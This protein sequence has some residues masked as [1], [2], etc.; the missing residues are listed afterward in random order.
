MAT[1]RDQSFVVNIFLGGTCDEDQLIPT[2]HHDQIYKNIAQQQPDIFV[3]SGNKET[4][5]KTRGE[6]LK[7]LCPFCESKIDFRGDGN[8]TFCDNCKREWCVKC[9]MPQHR[10]IPCL[11]YQTHM[12]ATYRKPI[13]SSQEH[14]IKWKVRECESCFEMKHTWQTLCCH[15]NM[16][17]MC[18]DTYININVDDGKV[19]ITCPGHSCNNVLDPLL[20]RKVVTYEKSQRLSF[21]RVKGDRYKYRKACPFCDFILTTEK[22]V[23]DFHDKYESIAVC[24]RCFREWCFQCMTPWHEGMTCAEYKDSQDNT[25]VKEWANKKGTSGERN[26]QRCPNCKV[27]IPSGIC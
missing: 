12:E 4:Q 13:I 14:T 10:G 23:V 8:D 17:F 7:L 15:T 16:C 26:A 27:S 1:S 2:Y 18:F 6:I 22:S 24:P 3:I 19:D 21:L 9:V 20:I 25:G 5:V 11:D